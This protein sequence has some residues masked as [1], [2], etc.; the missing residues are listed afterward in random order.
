MKLRIIAIILV[1]A[2]ILSSC[3]SQPTKNETT[4]KNISDKTVTYSLFAP[5]W[6]VYTG[7][8]ADRMWQVIEK[9][10]NVKFNFIG[11]PEG[12]LEKF[13]SLVNSGQVPDAFFYLTDQGAYK[14]Y[15]ENDIV[16]P[17][18]S[19]VDNGTPYLNKLLQTDQFV[20]TKINNK[21][22][23]MPLG[24]PDG[25]GLFVRRDWMEK[26]NIKDPSTMDEL[27]LMFRRFTEEDPDGDGKA[28]T[29]GLA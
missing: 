2:S 21:F 14:T 6:Q 20:N 1:F 25:V 13:S 11:A 19:V 23:F 15:V 24:A 5:G 18:D 28:N 27:A 9:K 26:L 29:V 8:P 4:N 17:L 12:W 3:A 16:L 10:F 7:K 22:Y